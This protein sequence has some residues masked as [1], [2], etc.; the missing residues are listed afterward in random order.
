MTD[1]ATQREGFATGLVNMLFPGLRTQSPKSYKSDV[2]FFY[3]WETSVSGGTR[4]D[5]LN[6]NKQGDYASV[7][8]AALASA[9]KL[10]S[11]Q[12]S[13]LLA[14]LKRGDYNAAK[15]NLPS[16]VTVT[17]KGKL[18]SPITDKGT[19]GQTGVPSTLGEIGSTIT[20]LPGAAASDAASVGGGI[21]K[22]LGNHMV[23]IV[24]VV[25]LVLVL[26]K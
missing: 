2:Q 3:D 11:K 9:A 16:D 8:A 20:S 1:V 25:A 24:L 17:G 19:F 15:K 12:E 14:A 5:P 13:T 10:R 23:L 26:K 7:H 6:L 18:P 4:L 21:G 22:L